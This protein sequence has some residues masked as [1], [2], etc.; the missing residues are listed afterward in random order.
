MMTKTIRTG[1]AVAALLSA[2][3]ATQAAD[4]PAP[5]YKAPAYVAPA[6]TSTWTG[7]YLG[8]NAGYGFGKSRWDIPA[9]A[10]TTGDFNVKGAMAGGTFG[11][12]YQTGTWVWGLEGDIDASWMK[13]SNTNLCVPECETKNTWLGTA[14]A[15]IGYA[16]WSNWLPYFTGGAA[17]G[18]IKATQGVKTFSKTNVGYA[19]GAG[20]EYAFRGP[21]SAKLEYLY[22]D[23]GKAT[24]DATVCGTEVDVKFKTNIIKLG[25]NYRF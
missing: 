22:A 11:Y 24:C 9:F 18:D 7:F 6:L 8:V 10:A 25:V 20:V 23:L 1:I 5:S 21:W 2:P 16:G 17:F 14:R 15:R 12:N 19:L 3:I 4:L 13:G